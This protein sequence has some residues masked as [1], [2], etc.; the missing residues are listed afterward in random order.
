[1]LFCSGSFCLSLRTCLS[2]RPL[3]VQGRVY[4]IPLGCDSFAQLPKKSIAEV[5]VLFLWFCLG[6]ICDL[7]VADRFRNIFGVRTGGSRI[8]GFCEVGYRLLGDGLLVPMDL[9]THVYITEQHDLA[10][11]ARVQRKSSRKEGERIAVI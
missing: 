7:D 5:P 10:K 8:I 3:L 11:I 2:I 6:K 1:M 4:K 9:I